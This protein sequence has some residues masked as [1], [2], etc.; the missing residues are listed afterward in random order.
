MTKREAVRKLMRELGPNYW[1]FGLRHR[2]HIIK[3]MVK[4]RFD[5][6]YEEVM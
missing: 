4:T 5:Y 1:I 6:Q 3:R 2:L